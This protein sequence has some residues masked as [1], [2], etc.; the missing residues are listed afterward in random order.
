LNFITVM[1]VIFVPPHLWNRIDE[2]RI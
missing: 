2:V 1:S